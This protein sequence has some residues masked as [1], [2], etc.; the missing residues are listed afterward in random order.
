MRVV[1]PDNYPQ[2]PPGLFLGTRSE[3]IDNRSSESGYL[4]WTSQDIS[5][6]KLIPYDDG[7]LI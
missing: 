6:W 1:A 5:R 2:P 4:S 7:Y 3:D